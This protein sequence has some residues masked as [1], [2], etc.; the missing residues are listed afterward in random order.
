MGFNIWIFHLAFVTFFWI[1]G[2]NLHIF[3]DDRH[4]KIDHIDAEG[5]RNFLSVM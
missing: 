4:G 3:F 2:E 1:N 5:K